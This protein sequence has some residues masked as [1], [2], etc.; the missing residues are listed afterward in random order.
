[1]RLK[2][3]WWILIGVCVFTAVAPAAAQ[4]RFKLLA[5]SRTGTMED[6]L[7]EAG[8]A[9][10]RFAGVQGGET[11]FGGS[12]A[13]VPAAIDAVAGVLVAGVVPALVGDVMLE[14]NGNPT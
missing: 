9:G 13:V 6:E 7:N 10:Y 12:E 8:A 11:A 5:T 14:V 3:L 4:E 1:M 2:K